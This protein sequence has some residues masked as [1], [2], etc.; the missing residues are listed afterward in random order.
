MLSLALV[1][2]LSQLPPPLSPEAVARFEAEKV[3]LLPGLVAK[4]TCEKPGRKTPHPL[5]DAAQGEQKGTA[6]EIRG[7]NAL[8][9][10]TW[11]VKRGKS[12][13]VEV[14][15]PW[16]SGLAL[17]KDSVGVWGAITD[18]TPENAEEKRML[19]RLAKDFAAML[20]GR[21]AS[22]KRPAYIDELLAVWSKTANHLVEQQD[23]AWVFKGTPITLRKVGERWV[24]LGA[25]KNG[26]GI[27]L[28]VF[29][30]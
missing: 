10:L 21:K 12:G 5:C 24:M 23:T 27:L 22:V 11:A 6:A 17:N 26:E 30:P 14:S 2:V 15:A 28:S 4:Y 29:T 18:I 7:K 8:M 25:P 1:L 20:E 9:G 16:L 13:K 3:V 19:G